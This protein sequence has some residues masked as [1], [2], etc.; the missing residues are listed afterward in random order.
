MYYNLCTVSYAPICL[1]AYQ[2][3]LF[4]WKQKK[5]ATFLNLLYYKQN[6]SEMLS[7]EIFIILELLTPFPPLLPH[8]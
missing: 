3:T 1:E 7:I 5:S 8:T 2:A 4:I 6:K